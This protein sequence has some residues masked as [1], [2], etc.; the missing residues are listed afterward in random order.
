M[1]VAKSD[2]LGIVHPKE[3][4]RFEKENYRLARKRVLEIVEETGITT[5]VVGLPLQIDRQE[6]ERCISVRRFAADLKLA[7]MDLVIIFMDE[8]YSTI[9]A[10]DRLR[11]SGWKE[12]KIKEVID[13]YS[14]VVILED[15][16][17]NRINGS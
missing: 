15:Y 13:M 10:H 5:I 4:F 12:N 8:S 14:A 17:R 6:G 1:G 16:M 2:L 3:E 9:E 7:N 11:D